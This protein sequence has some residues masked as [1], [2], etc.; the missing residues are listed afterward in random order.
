MI[1]QAIFDYERKDAR[2]TTREVVAVKIKYYA[3]SVLR[4]PFSR[5]ACRRNS[6][7]FMGGKVEK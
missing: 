6:P 4:L 2:W 7:L 1:N 3:A 5:A